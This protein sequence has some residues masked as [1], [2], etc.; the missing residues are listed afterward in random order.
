MAIL[1]KPINRVDGLLKVTGKAIYAAE[2]KPAGMVYA[3]PIRSTIANGTIEKWDTAAA[4]KTAWRANHPH[5]RKCSEAEE[6][7]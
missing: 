5:Q 7:R 6:V 3:F 2:Y 1:G 4:R